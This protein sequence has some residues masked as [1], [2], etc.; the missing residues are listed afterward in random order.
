MRAS[1]RFNEEDK[2]DKE[3][4]VFLMESSLEYS[5]RFEGGVEG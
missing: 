1:E 3:S 4:Q 5:R 2:K